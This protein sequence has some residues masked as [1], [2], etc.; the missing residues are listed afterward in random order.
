MGALHAGHASL[1]ARAR[2]ECGLVVVSIFVNPLQF[3]QPDDLLRYP[4]PFEDD[5][6]LCEREGVDV[7]FAPSEDVMYPAPGGCTVDPGRVAEHCCGRYR[8]GHFRGVATVVTKL[9]NIVQADSA[10]FGEKDAQ[11]L[12]LIRRLVADL[13]LPV[14]I[15]GAPT[16]R[17]AD[18]L[19]LSSRNVR[20]DA[21]G[22]RVAPV[23]YAAL[24]E[25]SEAIAGGTRDVEPLTRAAAA[26][27]GAAKGVRLEYFEVVDP[28]W[29]QPV[30]R[31]EGAVVIAGAVWVGS[32]RLIDNVKAGA[33]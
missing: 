20:L 14:T 33:P 2:A 11:Q 32:T 15:V 21:E 12:A 3:D 31:V 6:R 4:R 9:L 25:A 13:N 19:A 22:R 23:L 7:V 1:I 10:Y 18:G 17:E 28:D 27:I 8:P 30:T 24:R 26:R 16:V 5:L 29:F